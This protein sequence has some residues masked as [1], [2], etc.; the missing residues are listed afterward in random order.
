MSAV[1]FEQIHRQS[2]TSSLPISE[3][4][5][6][7]SIPEFDRESASSADLD[8]QA[9]NAPATPIETTANQTMGTQFNPVRER[10]APYRF[11]SLKRW[12]G[13]VV[14]LTETDLTARLT[15]LEKPSDFRIEAVIPLEEITDS[16]RDLVNEGAVFY[17]T[18]GYRIERSGQKSAV[19]TIRFRRLPVWTANDLQRLRKISSEYD[20]IFSDTSETAR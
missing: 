16:D 13:V 1:A 5:T 20:A 3:S 18:I 4:T 14:G 17:W 7:Q 9:R 15:N 2:P 12:E 6:S 10:L 11:R 8:G 19:S